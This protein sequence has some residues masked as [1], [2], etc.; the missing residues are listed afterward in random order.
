MTKFMVFLICTFL[1]FTIKAQ[2]PIGAWEAISTSENGYKIRSVVIFADGYQV[3]SV[4]NAT[5]GKFIHTNG[6]TWKLE[7]D[8]I[9][10]I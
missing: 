1:S 4:F 8:P 3:L 6:G 9:N 10:E 5:S 2:S 7:G